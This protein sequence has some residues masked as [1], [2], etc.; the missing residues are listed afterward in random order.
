MTNTIQKKFKISLT[1]RLYKS[2]LYQAITLFITGLFVD[3]LLTKHNV[4]SFNYTPQELT[5]IVISRL[6]SVYVNFS[7]F[8]VTYQILGHL[9]TC[10]VL[11][12][13]YVLLQ[14]PFSWQNILGILI[15]IVGMQLSSYCCSIESQQK[16]SAEAAQKS[17]AKEAESDPLLS[18][19]NGGGVVAEGGGGASA[20]EWNSNK[21]LHA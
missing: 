4:F 15:A 16:A 5:F 10:L 19:E 6:L 8:L 1:Q 13:G 7:T 12:F 9:K 2:C 17:Q 11:A 20:L 21:N 18:V 3:G 14:D